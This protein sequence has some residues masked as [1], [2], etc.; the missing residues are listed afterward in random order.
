METLDFDKLSKRYFH[1]DEGYNCA[2]AV[3]KIFQQQFQVT[4]ETIIQYKQNGGG[5]VEGNIC[6]ALYAAQQ[7]MPNH[8]FEIANYFSTHT[9]YETCREIKSLSKVSC[10]DCVVKACESIQSIGDL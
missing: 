6:G 8:S 2:Q 4:N 7:L 5:R 10:H 1:G 9:C 3:L